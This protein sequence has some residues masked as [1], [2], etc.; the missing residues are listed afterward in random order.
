[1]NKDTSH[2][3]DIERL[4]S[5]FAWYADRG[6]GAEMAALFLPD[7]VLRVGGQ[8]LAG[9]DA[10]AS[11]CYRRAEDAARKTRHVWSNLRIE[12]QANGCVHGTAIQLTFEMRG[13]DAPAHLRVNDVIDEFRRDA[14][15]NWRF[16]RRAIERQAALVL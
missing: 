10:I 3:A 6:C 5:D 11:D 13:P 4:L 2:Q 1:M 15:G 9:R 8:D 16:A 14:E 7:G 12:S